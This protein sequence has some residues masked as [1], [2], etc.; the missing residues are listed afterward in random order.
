MTDL[1]SDQIPEW[2]KKN[3]GQAVASV[4]HG[5][6]LRIAREVAKEYA[7]MNGTVSIE[8]VR[9][10]LITRGFDL[11]RRIN[12]LGSVFKGGEFEL[13]EYTKSRHVGSHARVIAV[14]RLKV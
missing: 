14:W 5:L 1:F 9:D 13:V 3:R 12:W 4:N 7:S 6:C 10:G 2:Q 8:N 11:S